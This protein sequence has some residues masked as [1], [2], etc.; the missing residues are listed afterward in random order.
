MNK[1]I[2]AHRNDEF[3]LI[4]NT[5]TLRKGHIF[6]S[7]GGLVFGIVAQIEGNEKALNFND[8]NWFKIKKTKTFVKTNKK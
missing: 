6:Q 3:R 1:I 5:D 8:K 2:P 7:F 4:K